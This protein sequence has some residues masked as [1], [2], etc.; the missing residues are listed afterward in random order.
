LLGYD[1]EKFTEMSIYELVHPLERTLVEQILGRAAGSCN[2]SCELR[3][4]CHNGSWL[5]LEGTITS[6]LHDP[7]VG[8]V[9]LNLRD[10]SGRKEAQF[11]L[12]SQKDLLQNL[13]VIARATSEAAELGD[14]L[15][16]LLKIGKWLTQAI[17]GSVFLFDEIGALAFTRSYY[18]RLDPERIELL[19]KEGLTSWVIQ[20]SKPALV[21]DTLTDDRWL[22]LVTNGYVP[23]SAVAIP[24]FSGQ[25]LLAIL[26]LT[27]ARPGHFNTGH[28]KTLQAASGQMAMAI[29][30][31]RLY[32]QAQSNLAD[33]NA[34]I[35]SSRDGIILVSIDGYIRVI[36][37]AAM[38]LTRLDKEPAELIGCSIVDFYRML[39]SKMPELVKIMVGQSRRVQRGESSPEE[40]ECQ[41]VYHHHIHWLHTPITTESKTIGWLVVLRDIT[42]RRKLEQHREELTDMIVHDLRNPASAVAGIV[43]ML[44]SLKHLDKI[45]DDYDQMMQLA[46]RNVSKILEL[47]Q[48]ILDVSQLESGQLP[49][50]KASVNL[51]QLIEETLQLQRPII[52]MK[53]MKLEKK[54]A[55]DLPEV[56]ADNRLVQRVLQNLVDNA[57]KFSRRDTDI[58]ISAHRSADNP[59]MIQVS[60]QDFGAGISP[61]LNG[62]IFDKF[63]SDRSVHRGTGI[64]LTFCRL[65]VQAHDGR[66][67]VESEVN[68]GS[69][70]HFTLPVAAA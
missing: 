15:Q 24:I 64:G 47:V 28:L 61:E 34:L 26:V 49:V 20:H 5:W 1:P 14:V 10:I 32:N 62:H 53:G 7:V 33:L 8:G 59:E 60:V 58:I 35:E 39:R 29:N 18:G 38:N 21:T 66:I 27:H 25:N 48:E 51:G 31:A 46:E 56:W 55:P 57:A 40:G 3:L 67:W 22:E 37:A 44:K 69:T 70:F 36:N 16:N 43:A 41:T 45:P 17:S 42:E 2:T 52:S 65:A 54:V 6:L 63:V 23:R 50:D 68:K 9:Y 4:K 19:L 12:Q 11:N 30:N 13:V